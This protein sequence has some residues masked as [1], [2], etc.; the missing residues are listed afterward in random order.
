MDTTLKY[1]GQVMNFFG[2][3]GVDNK[4]RRNLFSGLLFDEDEEQQ[5]Q[6]PTINTR[7]RRSISNASADS[8]Q[9]HLDH[10]QQG[11]A[12]PTS[13]RDGTTSIIGESEINFDVN[14]LDITNDDFEELIS[15]LDGIDLNEFVQDELVQKAI[16]D[17]VD[18]REYS[19]HIEDDLRKIET[20]SIDDY[21]EESERLADLHIQLQ[22]CDNVLEKMENML[23]NFQGSL[24]NISEEIKSL[25]DQSFTMNIKK[26]NRETAQQKL[27]TFVD[28][29]VIP[30]ELTKRVC[31]DNV[32]DTYL[33]HLLTLDEK[34]DY[35]DS[36]QSQV[37]R[38]IKACDDVL[39]I[40]DKLC[41][42]SVSKVRSYLLQQLNELKKPKTNTQ[43]IK[44]LLLKKKY[45]FDFVSKYSPQT[46]EEL[47]S[48]YD[49][50][51]GRYYFNSFKTYLVSLLKLEQKVGTRQSLIIEP[52][53]SLLNNITNITVIN[54]L[55][56][57]TN[58]L[59]NT[60]GL[61]S[62]SSESSVKDMNRSVFTLGERLNVLENATDLNS[63][64]V[65]RVLIEQNKKLYM[66]EIFRSV[67]ILL[68]NTATSEYI[69]TLD[70][71]N[72]EQMFESLFS[73][74]LQLL[75][76]TWIQFI[77][78]SFDCIG[79]LLMIRLNYLFSSLME[80]RNM[81]V[82]DSYFDQVHSILTPKLFELFELN[83]N[84]IRESKIDQL[85]SKE[86]DSH[87]LA[88]RFAE[89]SCSIH[90]LNK[91]NPTKFKQ[92]VEEQLLTCRDLILKQLILIS[93]KIFTT[94]QFKKKQVFLINS[95]DLIVHQFMQSKIEVSDGLHIQ[96]LLVKQV[97]QYIESELSECYGNMIN[98][99]QSTEPKLSLN[100]LNNNSNNSNNN[101]NNETIDL[102]KNFV[103][104][105]AKV[106]CAEMENIAKDFDKNWKQGISHI[107]SNVLQNF[108]NFNTGK[109]I[110]QK[111]FSQLV[112]YYT[113]FT[114][115]VSLCYGDNPPFRS[116][117]IATQKI[118]YEFKK[119]IQDFN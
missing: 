28:K 54:P 113:R 22:Q 92:Q 5:Q 14:D 37:K 9:H 119:Y 70:F 72:N 38:P 81:K 86:K 33:E 48:I 76:D 55:S 53:Q 59:A 67:H 26:R 23:Q 7:D 10:Q 99:I 116:S 91:E 27:S 89:F 50:I 110:L 117:I 62:K 58:M 19:K 103:Q 39:P 43:F 46:G 108:S 84:S 90:L 68:I 101:G 47:I 41:T 17:G 87:T 34:K 4:K 94:K 106:D 8:K 18:L 42:K 88:K 83:L 49:D 104:N 11:L 52:T 24:G 57:T 85:I 32:T 65:V 20:Q 44:Q 3:G 100:N 78:S 30:P 75:K 112:L 15:D 64:L 80:K 107:N 82:L 66:E 12:S 69:F 13:I 63:P 29:I 114:K 115:I 40:L 118:L 109:E 45:Y 71:F 79:I 93:E 16:Q 56:Y 6:Q 96:K 73:K 51:I 95:Y 1:T 2:R 98:F 36:I 21:L 111:A 60:V 105:R 25:R 74:S 97:D 35:I 102:N 77:S 61:G 31:D